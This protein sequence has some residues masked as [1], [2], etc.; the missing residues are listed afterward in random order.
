MVEGK[1]VGTRSTTENIPGIVGLGKAIEI[2]TQD[3]EKNIE[4]MSKIRDHIIKEVLAEIPDSYSGR[5][6]GYE[7][8]P[9]Q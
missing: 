1:S 2:G 9:M 7:Q 5:F 3:M 6:Q 8:A 4:K